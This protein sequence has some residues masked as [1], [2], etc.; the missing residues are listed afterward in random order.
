V[1]RSI[2][3]PQIV[4]ADVAFAIRPVWRKHRADLV[5]IPAIYWFAIKMEFSKLNAHGR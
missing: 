5:E 4:L 3:N 2:K 1:E